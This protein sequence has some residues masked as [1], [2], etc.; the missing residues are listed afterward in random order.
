MAGGIDRF[1]AALRMISARRRRSETVPVV[2]TGSLAAIEMTPPEGG[3]L[4]RVDDLHHLELLARR[5]GAVKLENVLV[6]VHDPRDL[7]HRDLLAG[8]DVVHRACLGDDLAGRIS[9]A[10]RDH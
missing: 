6:G 3:S 2:T 5:A 7:A 9:R 1:H 10:G 8:G 4:S